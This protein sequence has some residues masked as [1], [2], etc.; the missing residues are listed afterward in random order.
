MRI[1]EFTEQTV[2]AMPATTAPGANPAM[3]GNVAALADPKMQASMLAQQKKAKDDQRKA[4]QDQI[5]QLTKQ[6]ADLK[7]QL[8]SIR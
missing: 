4:I 1:F 2:G 8:T 3:T 5:T 7:T 6:L